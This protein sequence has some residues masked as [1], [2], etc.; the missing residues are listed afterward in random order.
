MS[1]FYGTLQG[2]R[3]QVT[4][5]GSGVSGLTTYAAGWGGAVKVTVRAGADGEDHFI[6]ELVP[7]AASGGTT[8]LLAAG[9]LDARWP[10]MEG[11]ERS[12]FEPEYDDEEEA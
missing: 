2:G 4:R 11:S 6:V 7:W 9:T 12:T 10:G 1:R 5:T 3:G 8:T